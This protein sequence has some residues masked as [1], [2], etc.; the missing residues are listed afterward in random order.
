M[1]ISKTNIRIYWD[2]DTDPHNPGYVVAWDTLGQSTLTAA[3]DATDKETARVEAAA[4]L[5]VPVDTV[6]WED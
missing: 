2:T 5:G 3:L 1:A 6:G 4:Q